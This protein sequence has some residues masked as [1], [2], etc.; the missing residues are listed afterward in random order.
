MMIALCIE[1]SNSHGMGH[2]FRSLLYV[3]Y[4]RLRG[5][6][7]IYFI[8]D[9][10]ES[11]RILRSNGISYE[12]VDYD[13]E[14]SNWESAMIQRYRITIWVNDRFFSSELAGKHIS[15]M[16]IR[17]YAIDESGPAEKYADCVIGGMLLPIKQN[18]LCKNVL[19][20]TKYVML[21]P[22]IDKYRFQRREIHKLIVTLGGA[23]PFGVTLEVVSELLSHSYEADIV[24][25]P[26]FTFRAE[27]QALNR[28]KFR[29]FRNVPSL[30]K[31]FADYDFAITGGGQTCCEAMASGLPCMVIA[32]AD[33]EEKTGRYYERLGACVYAGK[34]GTW[35]RG[36]ISQI[37]KLNIAGM[38][39]KGMELFDTRAVDRIFDIIL[40]DKHI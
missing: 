25:G 24:I 1:S 27:L 5:I 15:E 32:N 2:L 35:D 3:N 7:Y 20:G 30:M 36:I 9:D 19:L 28:G 29:I 12:V 16:G 34:H 6:S 14:Q 18:F 23:D 37:S 10:T 22:E 11:I 13:D 21:N 31:L 40:G 38:S 17:F 39:K 26:D 33:H 8:N 4:L